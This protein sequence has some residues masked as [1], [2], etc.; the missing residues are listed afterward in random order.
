VQPSRCG[1]ISTLLIQIKHKYVKTLKKVA[2]VAK[3]FMGCREKA[4]DYDFVNATKITIAKRTKGAN[5]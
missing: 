4:G 1:G 5:R 2:Y 3:I